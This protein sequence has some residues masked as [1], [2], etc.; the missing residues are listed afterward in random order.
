MLVDAINTVGLRSHH[1]ARVTHAAAHGGHGRRQA[2]APGPQGR[3]SGAPCSTGRARRLKGRCRRRSIR[4]PGSW[5]VRS[6]KLSG[7]GWDR[8]P[9]R[10][11]ARAGLTLTGA[12]PASAEPPRAAQSR[13]EPP[14][15]AERAVR[16]CERCV[17]RL[18]KAWSRRPPVS[19]GRSARALSLSDRLRR[20]LKTISS[21]VCPLRLYFMP[22]AAQVG[23]GRYAC[24]RGRCSQQPP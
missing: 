13:P 16:R 22:L 14:R 11:L 15:A 19:P 9:W 23:H 10:R 5:V 7:G 1:G 8:R 3:H 4:P 21:S 2:W 12:G 20:F 6:S 17:R 24:A 18:D